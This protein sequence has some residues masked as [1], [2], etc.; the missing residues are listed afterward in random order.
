MTAHFSSVHNYHEAAVYRTVLRVA[1]DYP[2]IGASSEL[3]A[4]VA[5]VALNALVPRYIRHAVDM[6]FYMTDQ[7][8]LKMDKAVDSAVHGAFAFVQSRTRAAE[9]A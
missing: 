2:A 5:C 7:E 9:S 8:R 4:D 3:L 6:S 1:P